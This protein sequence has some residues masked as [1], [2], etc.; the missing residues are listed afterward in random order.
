MLPAPPKEP[1]IVSEA[2]AVSADAPDGGGAWQVWECGAG[3]G[4]L[5]AEWRGGQLDIWGQGD[6]PEPS[7]GGTQAW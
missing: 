4:I 2:Q 7:A 1:Q 6:D 3:A 5:A